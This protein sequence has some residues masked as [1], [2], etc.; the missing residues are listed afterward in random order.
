MAASP[1]VALRTSAEAKSRQ[2]A[3]KASST[4]N[5]SITV[6]KQRHFTR[7]SSTLLPQRVQ[8]AMRVSSPSD[9]AEREATAVASAVVRMSAPAAATSP[10]AAPRRAPEPVRGRSRAHSMLLSPAAVHREGKG[11]PPAATQ[12]IATEIRCSLGGGQALPQEV[13]DFMEPRFKADFGAVRIH[14][15]DRAAGLAAR[16]GARA[17]A[18]GRDIFFARGAYSPDSAGGRELIAHELTHTIQQRSVAQS[19]EVRREA[20]VTTAPEVSQTAPPQVQRVGFDTAL[21]Y[22]ADKANALPGFRMLT[23]VLGKNP[24][25]GA[26]V[27]S[28]PGNVFRAIV[29]FI[30]GA[31][32]VTDALNNAGIFDKIANWA[33]DQLKGVISAFSSLGKAILDFVKSLG[34]KDLVN[35]GAAVGR[36]I[37]LVSEPINQIK[38][39]AA[40]FIDAILEF[41]K[42]A[43]LRPL[44]KLAEGTPSYDL[45]KGVMGE[46]PVTGD[47]VDAPAEMMVG[48]FMKIIGQEE[49][50][51]NIQKSGALGK[52]WAW[53]Q[54]A[55]SELK[56]FVSEIPG[57]LIA[58]LKALELV[59][60]VLVPR[61]FQKLAK[62]FGNFL[63]RFISWAGQAMWNLLEIIFEVVSPGALGYVKKVGAALKSILMNPLPFV[64]NLLAAG[65]GG[66]S[67][68]AGNFLEHLKKGLIDWL[69]GS[70]DGVYIPKALSL[71]EIVKFIFSVLGLTW[72]RFRVKLVKAF[73]ETV[74]VAMEKGF[75][76]VITLVNEGPAAAWDKIKSELEGLKEQV[77]QG[78]KDLVIEAV[79]T[80]GIPK[81]IAMFIPGAGFIGAIISIY[82]TVMVIVNQVSKIIAVVKSFVDSIVAI[83]NGNIGGAIAK[84]ESVLATGLSLAINF[85]AAF[86]GLG[87]ISKKI[88]G[89]IQKIRAPIDKAMDSLISW[90][91]KMAGKFLDGLKKKIK[92]L[93]QWWKNKKR[94]SAGEESHELS[95]KGSEES[96]T[97]M[98]ASNPQAVEAYVA[99]IKGAHTPEQSAAIKAVGGL[100]SKIK[101]EMRKKV[102]ED[103]EKQ[104]KQKADAIKA[105]FDQV[106]SQLAIL[107][108][109]STD[110]ELKTFTLG[111][112]SF[113]VEAKQQLKEDDPDQH[114]K[115]GKD[116]QVLKKGLARRH[117]VSS[118]DMAEHYEK[119]LI[120]NKWSIGKVLLTKA[121][122]GEA[123]TPV[124]GRLSHKALHAAA[125]ARHSK[126]FNYTENIFIG[127]SARNSEL[128]R[129]L[130]P[131]GYAPDLKAL[132]AHVTRIKKMW[133][134]DGSLTITE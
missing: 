119:A 82:D 62:V 35:P 63:S 61:A 128:G 121:G 110:S 91:K 81:L 66:F 57:L 8:A 132:R 46:D 13:R 59:D 69:T 26:A 104:V 3:V 65:K 92:Q 29:E 49:I 33:Y 88:N 74:A 27:D 34:A 83:A 115:T 52:C 124:T 19:G 103:D 47:A 36:G 117:V 111:R 134:M 51:R 71:G 67:A 108:D 10:A 15:D 44:G 20:A 127:P 99:S 38:S 120:K 75:D 96:A 79:I 93:F 24:V 97:L 131:D 25:N 32:L 90:I 106:A 80:R 2:T 60:I 30:P 113:T 6:V 39:L 64:G 129:R 126:F 70:L 95:F 125:K 107:M 86:A 16:L 84:V 109:L 9:P 102:K 56:S 14:T 4:R 45:L 68:F 21:N 17:F 50:Y 22:F 31:T 85:F 1:A 89:V 133:A 7:D 41:V 105:L 112:P 55:I 100:V 122:T 28:S 98:V 5:R 72:Q 42:E 118:K 94:F 101:T 48:G 130:D 73:G 53:F 43:I 37:H 40:G 116:R 76:I 23:I 114:R 78:I 18:F 54:G 77:I 123:N 12:E 87:K 11:T 58:G